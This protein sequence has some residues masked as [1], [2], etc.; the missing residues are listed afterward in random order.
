MAEIETLIDELRD[1][2][3]DNWAAKARTVNASHKTDPNT[4]EISE[5]IQAVFLA[6]QSVDAVSQYPI[7]FLLADR[8]TDEHFNFAA[9]TDDWSIRVDLYV[10]EIDQDRERLQRKMFRYMEDVVWPLLKDAHTASPQKLAYHLGDEGEAPE[11]S[12]GSIFA[13]GEDFINDARISVRFRK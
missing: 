5:T 11:I 7:V 6:E 3:I 9:D 1:Y 2:I 8:S 12:W 13:R 10:F 4:F